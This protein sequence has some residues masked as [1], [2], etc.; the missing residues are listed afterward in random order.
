MAAQKAL[1]QLKQG[2]AR[3]VSGMMST[4]TSAQLRHSP[5]LVSGQEPFAA[6]VGCSD[7]RV[8]VEIVFDQGFGDLF[9][10]RV[11]GNVATAAVIGSVEF[12][13]QVLGV[14][15]VVVLGHSQCGAV[16]AAVKDILHPAAARPAA[17]DSIV[18]NIKVK[19]DVSRLQKSE[20]DFGSTLQDAVMT[21]VCAAVGE[22]RHKSAALQRFEREDGLLMLGATYSLETGEVIFIDDVP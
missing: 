4:L 8:P 3:F 17:L 9:V 13:V 21:N 5:E 16:E 2:N 1:R 7:S 15:L 19:L 22:L 11:A 10:I 12:A 6:I 20:A 14:R 18:E